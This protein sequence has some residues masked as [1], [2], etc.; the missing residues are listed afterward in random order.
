VESI[1]GSTVLEGQLVGANGDALVALQALNEA[2]ALLAEAVGVEG[3]EVA[4]LEVH[5]DGSSRGAAEWGQQSAFKGGRVVLD[6]DGEEAAQKSPP[7][8]RDRA[9]QQ[10]VAGFDPY[11]SDPYADPYN[12]CV[13]AVERA[14]V[15]VCAT[16]KCVCTRV[17]G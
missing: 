12:P 9:L 7:V 16:C 6:D 8:Y 11:C 13:I 15:S 17:C 5:G 14:N 1:T 10:S 2:D 3:V 4:I